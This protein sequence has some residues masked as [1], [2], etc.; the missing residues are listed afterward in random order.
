MTFRRD[1]L[2][3]RP[4]WVHE[5][6]RTVRASLART[7][8]ADPAQV[9]RLRRDFAS[10]L[11]LDVA[12]GDL[13]DD[14]VL[15]VYETLAN[16][17]EHAYAYAPAEGAGDVRLV[18]ERGEQVLRVTVSD[19]GRWRLARHE[20]FRSRGLDFVHLLMN[21]VHIVSDSGGTTVHLSQKL[22]APGA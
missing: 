20:P 2:D 9:A 8:P 11:A 16:V 15:A 5:D 22:P 3:P 14:I 10:W 13:L 6:V 17:A 19:Q 12:P 4:A 18:A 7:A 21:R 1:A